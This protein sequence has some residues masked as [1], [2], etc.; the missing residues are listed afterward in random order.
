MTSEADA[1][2]ADRPLLSGER[3]TQPPSPPM[4]APPSASRGGMAVL[5]TIDDGA[6]RVNPEKARYES[7]RMIGEGAFGEVEL[8]M[9]NDIDRPVAI[10]RVRQDMVSA[11]NIARFV[12]EVQ[13]VG[14]LEHPGIVPIH[15]VGLDDSGYFFVMKYIDGETLESVIAKLRKKDPAYTKK[16]TMEH[17][18][19]LFLQLC[20][21][22]QFA[23]ARGI[24]HLDIKPANVMVGHFG[25]VVLMDWGLAKR[26]GAAPTIGTPAVGMVC[27]T[28]MYMSPEQAR[29]ENDRTDERSD[30]Y[31]LCAL[32]WELLALDHYLPIKPD[33][34]ALL[35]A[36]CNEAPMRPI[37]MHHKYAVPPDLAWLIAPGL[38]KNPAQR[39]QTVGD[40]CV[41]IQQ[42]IEGQAPVQ[43]P[44]T[45][46]KR[47]GGVWSDFIDN[48]PLGALA[49][50]ALTGVFAIVGVASTLW[51][52]VS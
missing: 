3:P 30:V 41:R 35:L 29:G 27:G 46:L 48:H 7:K 33:V 10:K 15:D 49:I 17:R 21:A 47:A 26:V 36:V 45:G 28:P 32:F 44:C 39:Y 11:D 52:I 50:A 8:A 20:R 42:A 2:L 22:V 18:T 5:P 25:E 34:D 13:V 43:C 31:A 19:Q 14:R 1:T 6:R 37:P 12:S 23:H 16:F 24:I 4:L 51:S 40:L 38:E 9:D